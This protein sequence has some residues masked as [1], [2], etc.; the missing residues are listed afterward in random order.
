MLF[1]I[2]Y[3]L[4]LFLL[5]S[6]V[7]WEFYL[8]RNNK[9]DIFKIRFVIWI[10]F[11]FFFGFRGFV[12]TDCLSYYPFFKN[13]KTIWD[14]NISYNQIISGYDWEPGFVTLVYIF[15][16]IL[17]NYQL[18]ILTWC[19]IFLCTIDFIFTKYTRYYSLSFLLFFVFEG[20]G[21]LTNLM[22]ASI[23]MC[24]FLLSIPALSESKWKKYLFLNSI[25]CLFHTSS[26]VYIIFGY[27]LK[28]KFSQTILYIICIIL[29]CFGIL[30]IDL[31]SILSIIASLMPENR[32]GLLIEN[33]KSSTANSFFTIGNIERFATYIFVCLSYK[34]LSEE[35]KTNL[36]FLNAYI[37]YFIFFFSFSG[38]IAQRLANLFVFSYWILYPK[39]Y[40]YISNM[41]KKIAFIYLLVLYSCLK[42]IS[43]M[44]IPC[45]QYKNILWNQESF[46]Q[47]EKRI[48]YDNK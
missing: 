3:L 11:I 43:G 35:N 38:V 34:K 37:L 36:L 32:I 10:T 39:F 27:V 30:G 16:S 5:V 22:R 28:R 8:K 47:A 31:S 29:F 7:F 44:S 24:F 15:K 45:H 18:W 33:Y 1:S 14:V 46:E 19:I 17:P 2:P 13:L 21:F 40:Q 4:F 48:K 26:V 20:Y 6:I 9:N 12:N 23:A 25:G 41:T 42:L